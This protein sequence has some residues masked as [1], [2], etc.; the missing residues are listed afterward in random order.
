MNYSDILANPHF[1]T[2]AAVIRKPFWSKEW[3]QSHSA[4]PFWQLLE[5]VNEAKDLGHA[6]V[7]TRF[8][9]LLTALA[10]ADRTLTYTE[11][12]LTWFVEMMDSS[13]ALAIVSLLL[14]YASAPEQ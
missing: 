5:N 9:E 14:A 3:R 2:L 6:D 13:E 4:V 1:K 10:I 12:D 7:T 8:C 11:E